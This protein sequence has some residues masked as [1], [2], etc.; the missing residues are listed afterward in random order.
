[1]AWT[2]GVDNN[3]H[4]ILIDFNLKS[5]APDIKVLN[6]NLYLYNDPDLGQYGDNEAN[7]YRIT[8]PWNVDSVTWN[9][10]P[11]FSLN[12]PVYIPP[13]T[14]TE[15]DYK[16]NVT[17]QIKEKIKNPQQNHGFLMKLITEEKYRAL[18]FA[19]SQNPDASKRPKLVIDFIE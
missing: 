10:C 14:K 2:E 12:N 17:T 11:A 18:R 3:D 4:R 6:S 15:Q 8:E 9:N 13:S 1:M 19:S 16:I 5:L 7:L